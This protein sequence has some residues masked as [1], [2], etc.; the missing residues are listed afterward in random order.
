LERK[1]TSSAFH[2]AKSPRQLSSAYSHQRVYLESDL[3]GTPLLGAPKV[4][5]KGRGGAAHRIVIDM[6]TVMNINAWKKISRLNPL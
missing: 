2:I 6:T 3:L 5:V 4:P 1:G